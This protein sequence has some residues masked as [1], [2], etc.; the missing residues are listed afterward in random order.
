VTYRLGLALAS[1]ALAGGVAGPQQERPLGSYAPALAH[2]LLGLLW[3]ERTNDAKLVHL[4]SRSLRRKGKRALTLR[5]ASG[6]W[7]FSPD[8]AR[9]VVATYQDWDGGNAMVSLRFVD[10]L[11]LRVVRTV[12]LG[13][14][15]GLESIAWLARDRVLVLGTDQLYV[16]DRGTG[17]VVDRTAIDGDVL[18]VA[19]SA[20]YLVVLRG[21]Q[22]SISPARLLVVAE[23][24]NV[25]SVPI[26][27]IAA[28]TQWVDEVTTYRHPGLAVDPQGE[29]AYV[30]SPEG[31]V[32]EVDLNSLAVAYR[33]PA[34]RRSLLAQAK[35]S[36]GP[37][38]YAKW[39]GNGLVAVAGADE[40]AYRDEEGYLQLRDEGAGLKI[41]DTRKWTVR[42]VDPE[43]R[44]FAPA[45]RQLLACAWLWD[46][47]AR[48]M[49]G[50][51]LA[52][53]TLDGR[54][55]FHLF[56]KKPVGVRLVYRGRA[57]VGIG[58]DPELRI[59]DLARG[60]VVGTRR[61]PLPWLLIAQAL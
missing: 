17:Q 45:G 36:A 19:R 55:R 16:V 54:K 22:G 18:Q 9:L 50:I 41:V 20:H 57:Y 35:A 59:V 6:A 13:R 3:S 61:D 40:H 26:D 53:Y 56:G 7:S 14:G 23:R 49:S 31:L 27:K 33:T 12:A 24:G 8:G 42:T 30:F 10:P 43:A 44:F 51:G 4:D 11:R 34:Q 15:G 48:R 2:P 60:R 25:R 1:V 38:R 52:A 5:G 47:A 32:A 39:L 29:R 37:S 21:S 46:S 28:G 58:D